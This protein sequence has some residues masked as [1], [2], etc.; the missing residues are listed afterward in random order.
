M[1]S[2]I[3]EKIE[4]YNK[5]LDKARLKNAYDFCA[6]KYADTEGTMQYP[7]R[8]LEIVIPL[9]PD[10]DTIIAI[11]LHELYVIGFLVDD[12]VVELFGQSVLKL[13]IS[14]KKLYELN[15]AEN[16]KSS[17][18]EIL[19]KMFLTMARDIRVIL[20][21]LA[22]RLSRMEG[23]DDFRGESS[24]NKNKL[25]K[26]TM[27]VYVPI[28]SRLGVYRIKTKLEDLSFKY[29]D[30]KEHIRISTQ[31]EEFG[32]SRRVAIDSIR[33][34]LEEFLKSKGID[35]FVFG[36]FK[37]V[38][39]IYKKLERKGLSHV[40]ELYDLFA[41]RVI[42]PTNDQIDHLYSVLGL[43]HSEWK[44][45]SSRFKDYVAVP[46]PNGYRSLHTVVLGLA[47]K[48]MDQP[49]EIQIRDDAMHREGEYGISSHW[50][51]KHDN[52]IDSQ[53][54][55]IRGLERIHEFFGVGSDA[56]KEV[57]I[58]VFKDRIFVLTPR[59]EV[60]DLTVGSIPIDFAYA[61]HTDVGNRCVMAKVNQVL[62]SLD[63]ELKNGDV[64]EII[65]RKDAAPKLRWLSLV[66]S[67]FARHKIKTYF[68]GL[69]KDNNLREGRRLLNTQLER[70]NKP[71][72]D[73]KYS[74]LRN[75]TGQK[76]S[77]VQRESLVEEVG[78]GAKLAS[79]V[80]RKVYPYE[81]NLATKKISSKAE[82]GLARV[83]KKALS[84]EQQVIV[85]D[86]EN[87]PI[88]IASCCKPKTRDVITGYVTRGNSI[89]IHKFNCSLIDSLDKERFI[90]VH[91]KGQKFEDGH[92]N[93]GIKVTCFSRVGLIHDITSVI[94]AMGINILDVIIKQADSGIYEDCFLLDLHDL[95]KFDELLNKIEDING[96]IKVSRDDKFK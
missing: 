53:S 29:L 75:Y 36:R 68:S 25:A 6:E 28:A 58:D 85:G 56:M 66:K 8:V 17:Q 69:N 15:Y 33:E 14:F 16:D 21:W 39:S 30:T 73:Q 88:K 5:D 65:T 9:K 22:A 78:K 20:I 47:P 48:D 94:T 72:L 11:L 92:L 93:V 51:Y 62:V 23:L 64:V 26:E 12:V 79:D 87:L 55:W 32:E 45:L 63:Y 37:S 43:I 82:P 77:T 80:V 84:L 50:V 44:P 54:E 83:N 34:K 86:E 7:M 27:E 38:Y 89:T 49:V 96:V 70:L 19:R 41:I 52:S 3:F 42:L 59:G 1:T 18:I 74:I 90:G 81:K 91:W 60:K 76:L 13:L 35:A 57:E 61:V 67:G 71:L 46:K 31:I 2:D 24:E 4:K 10:E 40:S 95:D